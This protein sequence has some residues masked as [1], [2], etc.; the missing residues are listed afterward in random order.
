MTNDDGASQFARDGDLAP[1]Q[2]V[3]I[4]LAV[5][6]E[7]V[8]GDVM[9][10]LDDHQVES[11]LAALVDIEN[12]SASEVG[13]ALAQSTPEMGVL[14]WDEGWPLGGSEFANV[15]GSRAIGP[16]ATKEAMNRILPVD[17]A[18]YT[19]E[20]VRLDCIWEVVKRCRPFV[21]SVATRGIRTAIEG[22]FLEREV[23]VAGVTLRQSGPPYESYQQ[24]LCP[25]FNGEPLNEEGLGHCGKQMAPDSTPMARIDRLV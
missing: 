25:H 18:V 4:V 22:S 16:R 10:F 2:R 13:R 8:S 7:V 23:E 20:R 11:V 9:K 3:A 14:E 21:C 24:P 5:L 19:D 6:G 15:A 1:L 12:V 17:R